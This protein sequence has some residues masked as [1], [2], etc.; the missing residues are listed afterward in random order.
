MLE[1]GGKRLRPVFTLLGYKI[2]NSDLTKAIHAGLAIE[3]F[4]NFTLLHD[5]IMDNSQLRRGKKTVFKKWGVD[6]AILSGDLMLVKAYEQLN[7]INPKLLSKILP[8]FNDCAI[9]ICEGQMLDI[10]YQKTKIISLQNYIK[11]IHLKTAVLFGF[12]LQA[13]ALSAGANANNAHLLKQFGEWMGIAFQIHDDLLDTFGDQNLFGKKV[14]QDIIS[15]KKTFLLVKAM[16]KAKGNSKKKLIHL[17]YSLKI[18]PEKK[19]IEIKNIFEELDIDSEAID[20]KNKYTQRAFNVLKK[21]KG[22][23]RAL[24]ELKELSMY[25]INRKS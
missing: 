21:I 24:A 22:N 18:T 2:Y 16:E 7:F 11:M 12:C 23:P 8:S 4:H 3:L 13:G 19:F 6:T 10:E 17:L 1:L 15:N 14:G 20:Y 9:K 25:L 5:D